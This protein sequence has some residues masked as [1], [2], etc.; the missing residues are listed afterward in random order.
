LTAAEESLIEGICL[1][2]WSHFS[3][4]DPPNFAT[5]NHINDVKSSSSPPKQQQELQQ[6]VFVV[7]PRGQF[8]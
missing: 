6:N 2:G 4:A 7:M 1:I 5:T 8:K 3:A